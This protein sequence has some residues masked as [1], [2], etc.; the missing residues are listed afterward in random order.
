MTDPIELILRLPTYGYLDTDGQL[1]C[2]LADSPDGP[3]LCGDPIGGHN[4]A[5]AA[6][7]CLR[8]TIV[9][10]RRLADRLEAQVRE[11]RS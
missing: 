3:A 9:E 1:P 8:C 6:P 5:S 11:G 10:L 4:Y 2:H 7:S